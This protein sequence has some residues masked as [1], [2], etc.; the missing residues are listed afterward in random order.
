MKNVLNVLGEKSKGHEAMYRPGMGSRPGVFAISLSDCSPEI[1][2][3]FFL[4]SYL[5]GERKWGRGGKKGTEDPKRAL[6]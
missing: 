5:L 3:T 2:Y 4:N 1:I 6:R